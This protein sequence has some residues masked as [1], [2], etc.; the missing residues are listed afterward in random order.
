MFNVKRTKYVEGFDSLSGQKED[1]SFEFWL[2]VKDDPLTVYFPGD[3][4]GDLTGWVGTEAGQVCR[5]SQIHHASNS[6]LFRCST[7]VHRQLHGQAKCSYAFYP[8]CDLLAKL[9]SHRSLLLVMNRIPTCLSAVTSTGN[10]LLPRYHR[11]TVSARKTANTLFSLDD[12]SRKARSK[13]SV[14]LDL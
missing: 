3:H 11:E 14:S 2:E 10:E 5:V 7:G 8:C 1:F 12:E 4:E 13:S 6:N 9:C